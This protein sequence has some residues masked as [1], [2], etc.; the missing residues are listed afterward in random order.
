MRIHLA[1]RSLARPII[2]AVASRQNIVSRGRPV[3]ASVNDAPPEIS[4]QKRVDTASLTRWLP[5][6]EEIENIFA[7]NPELER[8]FRFEVCKPSA[9]EGRNGFLT[10]ENGDS[11]L[12]YDHNGQLPQVYAAGMIELLDKTVEGAYHNGVILHCKFVSE[13]EKRFIEV[14]KVEK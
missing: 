12:A 9:F 11:L 10:D 4:L 13:G 5:L 14:V 3:R 1:R 2:G 6:C 7:E 8:K